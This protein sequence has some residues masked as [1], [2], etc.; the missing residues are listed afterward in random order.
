MAKLTVLVDEANRDAERDAVGDA[1]VA[2]LAKPGLEVRKVV[3]PFR[4]VPESDVWIVFAADLEASFIVPQKWR[5]V[6]AAIS[7]Q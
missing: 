7:G 5:L 6:V 3:G 4:A 1:A 2:A